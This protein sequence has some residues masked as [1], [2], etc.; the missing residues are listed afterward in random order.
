M[1]MIFCG[2]QMFIVFRKLLDFNQLLI[3]HTSFCN[4]NFAVVI[5]RLDA[6]LIV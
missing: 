1:C 3:N 4:V 6:R 2:A 5:A